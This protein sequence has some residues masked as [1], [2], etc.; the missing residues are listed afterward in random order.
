MISPA[1]YDLSIIHQNPVVIEFPAPAGI[2]GPGCPAVSVSAH[3][4]VLTIDVE[5][6]DL[7]VC[8][9]HIFKRSKKNWSILCQTQAQNIHVCACPCAPKDK[10]QH[11]CLPAGTALTL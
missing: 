6:R 2:P 3:A 9:L 1:V 10:L 5:A 8:F 11:T 4:N 7:S